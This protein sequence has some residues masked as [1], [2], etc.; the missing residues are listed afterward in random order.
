MSFRDTWIA[1]REKDAN[2]SQIH[3]ARKG[4]VTEEMACVAADEKLSPEFIRDEVAAGRLVICANVNHRELKPMGI[5]INVRCKINANL[6]NSALGSDIPAELEKVRTAVRFGADAIM[7]LSTGKHLD[8]TREAILHACSVP[9][10]TVPIY[11]ALERVK[12]IISVER[13]RG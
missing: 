13:V 11:E 4:V 1:K 8:E 5:G 6:G 2:R 9:V 7:D 12:G 3:Y 10:G